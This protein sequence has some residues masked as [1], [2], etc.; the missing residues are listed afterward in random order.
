M[1]VIIELPTLTIVKIE[2]MRLF[3]FHHL[4]RLKTINSLLNS[5]KHKNFIYKEAIKQYNEYVPFYFSSA[6][7]P[8]APE[9]TPDFRAE[10]IFL[11]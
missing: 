11:S 1:H 6:F 2:K 7:N 5:S 9:K 8:R 10:F 3:H 4:F